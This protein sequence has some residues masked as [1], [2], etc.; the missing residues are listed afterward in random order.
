MFLFLDESERW[1]R[2]VIGGVL[3]PLDKVSEVESFLVEKRVNHK[4]FGEIKWSN[5]VSG[6]Y[7]EKYK[8][9]IRTFFEVPNLSYH[10][11]SYSNTR[12]RYKAA[13]ITIRAVYWK[14]TNAGY[15]GDYYVLLDEDGEFGRN[16]ANTIKEYLARD[17][18]FNFS[19]LKFCSYGNSHT[20]NCMQLSDLLTGAVAASINNATRPGSSKRTLI[21]FVE[22]INGDALGL[23]IPRF[24]ALEEYKMHHFVA[25]RL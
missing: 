5:T 1:A 16:G 13:Y 10:S 23:N 4:L 22:A 20:M 24:P 25:G 11:C 14:F 21:D 17:S 15:F 7:L 8:D 3:C 6:G 19:R 2:K 18:K 9:Y 12:N